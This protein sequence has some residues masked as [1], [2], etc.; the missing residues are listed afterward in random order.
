MIIAG[1]KTAGGGVRRLRWL[2][3]SFL[4]F[5]ATR[6]HPYE[7]VCVSYIRRNVGMVLHTYICMYEYIHICKVMR[8]PLTHTYS[9]VYIYKIFHDSRIPSPEVRQ[10]RRRD[11]GRGFGVRSPHGVSHGDLRQ[12]LQR[13]H[14]SQILMETP[15]VH[16]TNKNKSAG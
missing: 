16:P 14:N 10:A 9:T 4:P 12:R 6:H 15:L 7:Y 2:L 13:P 8:F 5:F 1:S 11:A 3:S